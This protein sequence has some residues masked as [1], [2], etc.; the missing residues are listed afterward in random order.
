MHRTFRTAIATMLW[1]LALT[2][3]M[4][5]D[6][7]LNVSTTAPNVE[8][9][10]DSMYDAASS[11]ALLTM[12]QGWRI[13]RE[14]GAPRTVGS[15]TAAATEVMYAGGVSLAS[16]AKNGTWNFG[17]SS[18][19]SDR[20][21][22]GLSTTVAD[23]TRCLSVMTHLKNADAKAIEQLSISYDIENYRKGSNAQGFAV[24]MYYSTDGS[25]W[26]NAG[27]DF[28]NYFE[29][30][31][32]TEGAATVPIS[33]TAVSKRNLFINVAGGTDLYLAWNITVAGGSSPNQAKG[34]AIDNV[35][36]ESVFEGTGNYCYIYAED[37]TKWNTLC[38]NNGSE[39][40]TS[41]GNKQVNGVS[42]KT[43]RMASSTQSYV[44]TFTDN[45]GKQVAGPTV[46]ADRNYY[47]CVT[48]DEVTAIADPQTYTGWVD[49]SIPPF[50]SSGIYLRGDVNSWG[51]TAEWEFSN[52]GNGTYALYDKT[53]SGQFKV[54]DASWSSAC[55][56]G[57]NGFNIEMDIPYQ[58]TAGTN[59]NISV[60]AATYNCKRIVLTIDANGATLLLQSVDKPDEGPSVATALQ[61]LPADVVLVPEVPEKVRVLS[62]NNSLIYYNDQ[63][64]VFNA[65]AKTMGKDAAWTK[66]TLLGKSLNAHWNEGDGLAADGTKGAKMMVRSEA[67]THIIL[68]EQSALPR[69]DAKTF[70]ENVSK[71]IGYIRQYC[72][73]P[74]AVIIVPM[75]WAYGGDWTNYTNF[76]TAFDNSYQAMAQELGVVVCPVGRAY[77]DVYEREGSEATLTWFLDDR[78][79]TLK[80]TYMAACMEYATI[81]GADPTTITYV[82]DGMTADEAQSMR[83]YA[84]RAVEG[85]QNVVN[86]QQ[87]TINY[88]VTVVDQ[89]GRPMEADPI[90]ANVSEGATLSPDYVFTT[91]ADEGTFTLNAT[92]GSFSAKANVTVAKAVTDFVPYASITLDNEVTSAT[93][94]F[95][96]MAQEGEAQLPEAWR[97]DR[98]LTA[99]TVGSYA[100]ASNT[101]MYSGG[102]NLP[103]NA[104][105]GTWNFGSSTEATDRAVGGITTGVADG[106]RAINVYTHIV[107]TGRKPLEQLQVDYDIE[108][109]RTGSNAE[110]FY[111]QLYY[112]VDGFNWTSA[113]NNFLTNYDPDVATAGSD[114]VPIDVRHVSAKL[115]VDADP[116]C[117]LFLAWNISVKSGAT[118]ASA[119]AFAIDN[120]AISGEVPA[121]PTAKHYVYANDQTT[122]EALGLYAW[123]DGELFG[124]WP[125]E[126]WVDRK[127]IDDVD[128]KVFLLDAESGNY[129]LIFNNWNN[130]KQLPD[131][132]IVANRDYYL[133]V[134]DTEVTELDIDP[135][136][137]SE[138]TANRHNAGKVYSLQG[139]P[140]S[141]PRRGLY[142]VG[143][144][145]VV[146]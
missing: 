106:S 8:Q 50:V 123:G 24:Q 80:A 53:I 27:D 32:A 85:Y 89:Y 54:A 73:N 68:Q 33:T 77:Q 4:A 142:I 101:T 42:Y 40:L 145:K 143:G 125:G 82:P 13:H 98:Q 121:V 141:Q 69:T 1:L 95:D 26:T 116:G 47:F 70:R 61:I 45:A 5:Q 57:S 41:M 31:A 105:N 49:P 140:T 37:V 44:L 113:G 133:K 20:A 11:E 36:I 84:K 52:E 7:A 128:F 64:A 81:F 127:T 103:S 14:M 90:T 58:L 99:R 35:N 86:H 138:V 100:A 120:F 71:W 30:D 9:T 107:N 104:K 118:A 119:P 38:L 96:T 144:R 66:H 108:R 124:A 93:E 112:S 126:T 17:S 91:T 79:P 29:P 117:D 137:I 12:P 134:T 23:A 43:F 131:F 6:D 102:V 136:A 55:N 62:L 130:G 25:T 114:V 122:Y 60:G 46:T 111:V 139:V 48:A 51:A 74:N 56:Y 10:F 135:S 110:G 78:H 94:N 65:M 63:D 18:E 109:Y 92:S 28:Y 88:Q 83:Q 34:L 67:W 15:W 16:N 97:I 22:G 19:P 76:N 72:P 132:D 39:T 21:V 75:N 115:P 146:F 3:I 2:P 59:S 129:H 87:K